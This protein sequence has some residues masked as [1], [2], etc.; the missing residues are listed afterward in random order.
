MS[1][2]PSVYLAALECADIDVLEH[3]NLVLSNQR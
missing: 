2:T 1:E 3:A